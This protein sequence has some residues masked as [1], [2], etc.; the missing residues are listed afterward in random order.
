M[1]WASNTTIRS[2]MGMVVEVA[3]AVLVIMLLTDI[4]IRAGKWLEHG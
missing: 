1:V 4:G 2:V 3:A